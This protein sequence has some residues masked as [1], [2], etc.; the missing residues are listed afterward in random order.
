MVNP[1]SP[2]SPRSVGEVLGTGQL[3]KKLSRKFQCGYRSLG[4]TAYRCQQR[5]GPT[6]GYTPSWPTSPPGW[7]WSQVL[8][9]WQYCRSTGMEWCTF[10]T[11]CSPSRSAYT[12]WLGGSSPA[13]ES[14][15]Y[16]ASLPWSSC[17]W[18]PFGYS[19]PCAPCQWSITSRGGH[20]LRVARYA[21]Q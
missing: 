12:P 9:R 3:P 21:M 10:C 17:P 8:S 19:A 20:P 7:T 11:C 16:R 14:F 1:N 18:T 2:R 13:V 4:R 5:S 15:P 6:M